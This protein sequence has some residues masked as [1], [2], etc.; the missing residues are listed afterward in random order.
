MHCCMTGSVRHPLWNLLSIPTG[1]RNQSQRTILRRVTC[2]CK[3]PFVMLSLSRY[4]IAFKF[5]ISIGLSQCRLPRACLGIQEEAVV[6]GLDF[7]HKDNLEFSFCTQY[8]IPRRPDN[9]LAWET[10]VALMGIGLKFFS[11]EKLSSHDIF[12]SLPI[13]KLLTLSIILS[14]MVSFWNSSNPTLP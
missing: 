7:Q 5:R 10:L 14:P 11:K 3:F 9:C 2:L 8:P 12:S 13:G 6:R 1:M 4:F